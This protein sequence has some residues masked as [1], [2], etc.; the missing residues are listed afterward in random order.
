MKLQS[1]VLGALRITLIDQ[2]IFDPIVLTVSRAICHHLI[3]IHPIP[4]TWTK[5]LISNL[6]TTIVI[7]ALIDNFRPEDRQHL[8]DLVLTHI[9]LYY[10]DT[11]KGIAKK[12]TCLNLFDLIYTW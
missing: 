11:V 10:L 6:L 8:Y 7:I 2:L 9:Y 4:D 1:K 12:K 3:G 5:L